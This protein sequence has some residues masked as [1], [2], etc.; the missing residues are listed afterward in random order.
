MYPYILLLVHVPPKFS[1]CPVPLFWKSIVGLMVHK[2]IPLNIM[3]IIIIFI[4]I[5]KDIN[6]N[7]ILIKMIIIIIIN[8]IFFK[9]K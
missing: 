6:N 9:P 3:I 8:N 5:I 7:H 1:V 2:T 4:I